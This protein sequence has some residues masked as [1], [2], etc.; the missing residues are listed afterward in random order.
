ML[1]G[2]TTQ[3]QCLTIIRKFKTSGREIFYLPHVSV[4]I[5]LRIIIVFLSISFYKCIDKIGII[6]LFIHCVTFRL[7]ISNP[8]I[9]NLDKG[10]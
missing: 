6:I 4:L 7:A 2:W 5:Q 8:L 10:E 3:R 1:Y 9:L